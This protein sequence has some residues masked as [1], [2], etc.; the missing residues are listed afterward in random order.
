[1]GD[2]VVRTVPRPGNNDQVLAPLNNGKDKYCFTLNNY[3]EQDE[4]D[5]VEYCKKC[6]KI[7]IVARE[8]CPTTGTPHLQCYVRLENKKRWT[9]LM[10]ECNALR[11]ASPRLKTKGKDHENINYCRKNGNFLTN[12]RFQKPLKVLK[13]EELYPWQKEVIDII[14]QPANGRHVRWYWDLLGNTGKS[15]LCKYLL[16]YYHSHVISKGKYSDIMNV[17]FNMENIDDDTIIIIDIPRNQGNM[18]SYDA[19]ES[20]KNGFVCNTKY[21]TGQKIFN[22]PHVIVFSNCPPDTSKLSE[23]RWIIRRIEENGPGNR[24]LLDND[25]T[26]SSP[27]PGGHT[28][29]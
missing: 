15:A 18:V 22:S 13:P 8:I 19:I 5:I 2:E 25:D 11:R 14:S 28:E 26:S 20:I 3:T 16:V 21:E 27:R 12:A 17:I 9:T 4:M 7:W 24:G 1:M 23:D 29:A 10:N 6:S